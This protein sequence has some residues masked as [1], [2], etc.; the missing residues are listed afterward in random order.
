MKIE[1]NKGDGTAEDQK[2]QIVI[3][4]QPYLY[5]L[6]DLSCLEYLNFHSENRTGPSKKE[7]DKPKKWW[8]FCLLLLQAIF[9]NFNFNME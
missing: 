7:K 1:V 5:L 8:L 2:D 4:S 9:N 6:S 3:S